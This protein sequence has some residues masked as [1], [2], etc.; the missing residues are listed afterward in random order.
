MKLKSL[1]ILSIVWLAVF[2]GCENASNSFEENADLGSTESPTPA[3]SITKEQLQSLYLSAVSLHKN[4]FVASQASEVLYGSYWASSE[5]RDRFEAVI[6]SVNT[7]LLANKEDDYTSAYKTLTEAQMHFTQARQ[8]G[9]KPVSADDL[10]SAYEKS[11]ILYEETLESPNG[12]AIISDTYWTTTSVLTTFQ[13]VLSATKKVIDENTEEL[14]NHTNKNLTQNREV[15]ENAR[16]LGHKIITKDVLAAAYKDAKEID[17]ETVAD[18]D[19]EFVLVVAYWATYEAKEVFNIVLMETQTVLTENNETFYNQ[20]YR[21]LEQATTIFTDTRQ[22]GNRPLNY[23]DISSTYSIVNMYYSG[24]FPSVDGNDIPLKHYWVPHELFDRYSLVYNEMKKILDEENEALYENIYLKALKINKELKE[25]WK[26]GTKN[27]KRKEL[28]AAYEDGVVLYNNTVES[29]DGKE[30]TIHM[31]WAT[32]EV[33]SDFNLQL[34]YAKNAIDMNAAS[35]Y[36][37][38]YG[39]LVLGRR[40]FES[41]RK[42]GTSWVTKDEFS[43][44]YTESKELYDNTVISIDGKE[45]KADT[46]WASRTVKEAFG[47]AL[48]EAKTILDT[49][50]EYLYIDASK[51]LASKK[52]TFEKKRKLGTNNLTY[53]DIMNSYTSMKDMYDNTI[54]SSDGEDVAYDLYWAPASAMNALDR[55]LKETKTVLDTHNESLY[56]ATNV[57]LVQAKTIFEEERNLKR[58]PNEML[59]KAFKTAEQL[60]QETKVSVDG[61]EIDSNVYWAPSAVLN[62]FNEEIKEAKSVYYSHNGSLF[63]TAY[64]KII[65]KTEDFLKTRLLGSILPIRFTRIHVSKDAAATTKPPYTI[66]FEHPNDGAGVYEWRDGRIPITPFP[67]I[68]GGNST[69]SLGIQHYLFV[70]EKSQLYAWGRNNG[71]SLGDGTSGGEKT[72]PTLI[73]H[74]DNIQWETVSAGQRHSLG[75]TKTGDLYAWGTNAEGQLGDGTTVNKYRPTLIDSHKIWKSVAAGYNHSLAITTD[76]KLYAWGLNSSGQLGDGTFINKNTPVLISTSKI[77][78]SISAGQNHSVAITK[79]NKLYAWGSNSTGQLGIKR[80][81]ANILYNKPVLIATDKAWRTIV[82]GHGYNLATTVYGGTAGHLYTWGDNRNGL[83]G[84]NNISLYSDTPR[85]IPGFESV[86]WS[87]IT[88]GESVSAGVTTDGKAYMWGKAFETPGPNLI[89]KWKP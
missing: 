23:Y 11:L 35:E 21:N 54:V 51:V 80:D 10:R 59:W 71:G 63:F 33:L 72:R 19:G 70:N 57:N 66:A 22:T 77:W 69:I 7:I 56:F 15:F 88:V 41:N 83:I 12:D 75:I 39:N 14:F 50:N 61:K 53:D 8:Q 13:S 20:A 27:I 49:N 76:N 81:S 78:R 28:I 73:D 86:Q 60:H 84:N 67:L 89:E 36:S 40:I 24:T 5:E 87:W 37:Y 47:V 25:T 9:S 17:E 46:Y 1:V 52:T 62:T 29:P 55:V 82:A 2:I 48:N 6:A 42:L 30:I 43:S 58:F 79:E 44:F 74:G 85:L 32:R 38:T 45:V 68:K 4:T 16:Q 34:I 18:F 3:P 64:T 31:Y 26:Y 65:Q